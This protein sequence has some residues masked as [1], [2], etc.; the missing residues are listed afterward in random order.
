MNRIRLFQNQI[1]FY[2]IALEESE[3]TLQAKIS[4]SEKNLTSAIVSANERIKSAFDKAL[5]QFRDSTKN[6]IATKIG[7][8]ESK[9]TRSLSSVKVNVERS[10]KKVTDDLRS[11]LNKR[12]TSIAKESEKTLSE[13]IA[14]LERKI[15]GVKRKSENELSSLKGKLASVNDNISD[16]ENKCETSFQELDKKLTK[17][18]ENAPK[19]NITMEGISNL[20]DTK[21]KGALTEWN[22]SLTKEVRQ[23]ITTIALSKK[24]LCNLPYDGKCFW[25]IEPDLASTF[26]HSK[27]EC[28]EKGGTVANIYSRNHYD[29]IVNYLRSLVKK[30]RSYID[31]WLGMTIDPETGVISH[32]DGSGASFAQWEPGS[33]AIGTVFDQWTNIYLIVRGSKTSS[34]QGMVNSS[35]EDIRDAVLCEI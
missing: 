20:M 30:G 8:T 23:N 34:Y 18:I 13:S 11:D 28:E 6:S 16:V 17:S 35:P 26:L 1:D 12:I 19:E 33:P 9:F 24:G 22:A 32:Q 27:Y 5:T 14:K 15:D 25:A 3:K 29:M 7:E 21:I 31:V 10:I 4:A 2:F